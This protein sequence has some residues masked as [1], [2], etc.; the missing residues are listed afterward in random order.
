MLFHS[1]VTQTWSPW[2]RSPAIFHFRTLCSSA[3]SLFCCPF[4]IYCHTLRMVVVV[5]CS[6]LGV[7]RNEELVTPHSV[8]WYIH[9]PLW[10]MWEAPLMVNAIPLLSPSSSNQ[11][12]TMVF[13]VLVQDLSKNE[14]HVSCVALLLEPLSR[15]IGLQS[16]KE[17]P[18]IER[19]LVISAP[20]CC[21]AHGYPLVE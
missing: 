16:S 2:L 3:E 13:D 17:S 6:Y 14:F 5:I 8:Q 15:Q 21:R 20:L 18:R 19:A 7:H 11:C 4:H 9:L 10:A 12:Y 1:L